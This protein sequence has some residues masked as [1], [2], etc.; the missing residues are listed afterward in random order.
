[1]H[2]RF[3]LFLSIASCPHKAAFGLV[4]DFSRKALP[5]KQ[6]GNRASRLPTKRGVKEGPL[7]I[8]QKST[9]NVLCLDGLQD[10]F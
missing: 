1:M 7:Q 5:T 3:R 4:L 6:L 9:E 10:A 2:R 8:L